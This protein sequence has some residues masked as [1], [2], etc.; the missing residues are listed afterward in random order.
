LIAPSPETGKNI[1]ESDIPLGMSIL[2]FADQIHFTYVLS[3]LPWKRRLCDCVSEQ[4][5]C[6][7][8]ALQLFGLHHW[9]NSAF[10]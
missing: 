10:D 7:E 5:L 2:H 6:F 1:V 3:N 9:R 4:Y 8:T